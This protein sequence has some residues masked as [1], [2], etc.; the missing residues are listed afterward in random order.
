MTYLTSIIT[1]ILAFYMLF[2][3]LRGIIRKKPFV[4]SA[5][6]AFWIVVLS[7]APGFII[8]LQQFWD[9]YKTSARH[10]EIF[11]WSMILAFLFPLAL[12]PVLFVFYRRIMRGYSVL[13][14]TDE[15]FR[16][17]L[18]SVLKN[19]KLPFEERLSKLRLTSIDADLE[20]NIAS[21]MGTASLRVKQPEHQK[22]LD[23]I[24]KALQIY[25]DGS[26]VS[27]NMTTCVYY[28]IFGII[29]LACAGILTYI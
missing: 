17:A 12:Y 7:L 9:L 15:S 3:G 27:I 13:G 8:P 2:M 23:Q 21:W 25:F 10:P 19:L 11:G 14:I 5:K 18:Y 20:V 6:S 29:L 4:F 22:T 16:Q 28:T 24:A 1:L 26:H